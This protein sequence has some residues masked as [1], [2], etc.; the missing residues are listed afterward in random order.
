[1]NVLKV[2][3]VILLFVV[4]NSDI[5][6][7]TKIID[8]KVDVSTFTDSI[9]ANQ[10]D[11]GLFIDSIDFK[12]KVTQL[13]DSSQQFSDDQMKLMLQTELSKLR[14]AHTEVGLALGDRLPVGFEIF[15]DGLFVAAASPDYNSLL[16]H[17]IKY[18]NSVPFD[19]IK[20][21]A[22]DV[23][24]F[25]N[26]HWLQVKLANN[27]NSNALLKFFNVVQEDD[28]VRLKTRDGIEVEL[29]ND[30]EPQ[31]RLTPVSGVQ[32]L[33]FFNS[34]GKYYWADTINDQT[35]YVQYNRC[36]EHESL[37]IQK[38]ANKVDSLISQFEPSRVIFDLR[39]N[40]GGN[41]YL[42]HPFINKLKEKMP[43]E[44]YV[45]IGKRTF[46]SGVLSAMSLKEGFHAKVV[47][48][49]TGG[50]PNSYG[51]V[52]TFVLPSS[53]TIVAYTTQY[54]EEGY[55]TWDTY[56]PDI[57]IPY[58]SS[59]YLNGVDPVLKYVLD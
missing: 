52:R 35:L 31:K 56:Y 21:K 49:P 53:Q 32:N 1:M 18:I 58:L 39:M 46:S 43:A 14:M 37:S 13:K 3:I 44:V 36:K 48:N 20:Q 25:E 30:N 38:F 17:E 40:G 41:S 9:I 10:L 54:I 33:L 19:D 55:P 7:Q 59:S 26:E 22:R 8:W 24:S 51:E 34:K 5:N 15:D 12:Y 50:S 11:F 23:F 2:L 29:G 57:I 28:I 27:L 47:G 16:G 6:C 42:I 45:L 4:K